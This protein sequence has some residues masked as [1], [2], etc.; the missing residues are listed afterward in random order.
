MTDDGP[1]RRLHETDGTF[2]QRVRSST[3]RIVI[4]AAGVGSRLGQPFPKPLTQ[5]A[6]GRS[7]MQRQ[8]DAF[9]S[10]LPRVPISIVVGFK[11]DIIMEAHPTVSYVYNERFGE[12]NTS[13]SLLRGLDQTF[14]ESVLWVNGDVVFDPPLLDT[15]MPYIEA[16]QSFVSVNRASVGDEEVKYDLDGAGRILHLSKQVDDALGEAVGINHVAAGD[17]IALRDRLEA[18]ADDDYFERGIELAIEHDSVSFR[19]VD[20]TDT[21]CIEVDFLEDLER[22][23]RAIEAGSA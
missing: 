22:A 14:D 16:E 20:V 18:C 19:P 23:N 3:M 5:L 6:D 8:L 12:T 13:K 7:I 10:R 2:V 15:L 1:S 11:K 21:L 17:V 4:L 9:S